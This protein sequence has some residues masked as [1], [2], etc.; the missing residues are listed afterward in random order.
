MKKYSNTKTTSQFIK[1]AKEI[2]DNLYD[3]SL[4]EYKGACKKV[5]IICKKHGAFLQRADHHLHH[6]CFKCNGFVRSNTKQFISKALEK[7]GNLYGYK[8]VVYIDAAFT[9]VKIM[10]CIHGIFEQ[11]P[12]NH[13]HGKGCPK[14]GII[15]AAN[16]R[17]LSK[18]EFIKKASVVHNNKFSYSLVEYKNNNSKIN[19]ICPIHGIFQQKPGKH[20]QGD[21]CKKCCGSISKPETK[22]L[23]ELSIPNEYRQY[24]ITINNTRY[25]VDGFDLVSNTIYEFL[26]D[27]WH[28]NP[29][30]FDPLDI[31]PLI[32]KT[33]GKL[34]K[35][36]MNKIRLFEQNGY[37]VNYIR[38]SDYKAQKGTR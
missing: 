1:E 21:G 26:G 18:E 15:S 27:F 37:K 10:C 9:K 4:T 2:H 24:P 25:K 7:H 30:K 17:A 38:E 29:K 34:Y 23:D 3:Y 20:L 31:H 33:Y 13:I 5:Q 8:Q 28:G 35:T 19:I 6:G 16:K 32:Q 22:W 12:D 14:C 36:A 11:T